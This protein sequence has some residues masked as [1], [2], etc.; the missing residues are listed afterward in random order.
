MGR[1]I[2]GYKRGWGKAFRGRDSTDINIIS[3]A[4]QCVALIHAP[5]RSYPSL[6]IAQLSG[7]TFDLS[8][9]VRLVGLHG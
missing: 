4:D 7:P 5:C 8:N 6:T 9:D 2:V 1:D 3:A